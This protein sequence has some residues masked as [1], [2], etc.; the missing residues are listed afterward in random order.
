MA[1]FRL[2]GGSSGCPPTATP[3]SS[4]Q[5]P[6]RFD[7]AGKLW[8]TGCFQGFHYFGAARHDISGGNQP[9]QPGYGLTTATPFYNGT[10]VTVGTRQTRTITNTTNCT[11]GFLLGHDLVVDIQ[12]SED[13][14][15]AVSLSETW[16][17][18]HHSSATLSTK[19]ISAGGG[20]YIR[21]YLH[22]SANPHD[23]NKDATGGS[24]LQLA[25]GASATIGAQIYLRYFAGSPA[26][27]D[28]L[29]SANSA[30]RIYG[31]VLG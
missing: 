15:A 18:V 29:Y 21:Q 14:W 5:N 4:Y 25:P 27:S 6:F 9:G 19:Y 20:D 10:K 24:S 12:C 30:V 26:G 23:V 7:S 1:G 3:P 28:F 17:G 31:Y 2:T 11:L 16:N 13:R 22:N 8:I